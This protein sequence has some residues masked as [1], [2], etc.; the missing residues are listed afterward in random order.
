[1]KVKQLEEAQRSRLKVKPEAMPNESPH[2]TAAAIGGGITR[3][4]LP[5]T[6]S[7]DVDTWSKF[8]LTKELEEARRILKLRAQVVVVPKS[9]TP[10]QSPTSEKLFKSPLQIA[11]RSKNSSISFEGNKGGSQRPSQ[12]QVVPDDSNDTQLKEAL[13]LKDQELQQLQSKLAAV[14]QEE[15]ITGYESERKDS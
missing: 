4:S 13:K 3:R 9:G 5:S 15:G 2:R 7:E 14:Q 6:P 8:N 1:M 10:P 11:E 12:L